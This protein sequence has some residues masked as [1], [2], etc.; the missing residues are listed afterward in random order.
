MTQSLT[1]GRPGRPEE[2][3]VPAGLALGQAV[4]QAQT[5][6]SGLLAAALADTG[7]PRETY[8]ALQRLALRGG[9][10]GR[11]EYISDLSDSLGMDL[12]AATEL[13]DGMVAG[14][15]LTSVDGTIRL[16]AAG[17]ELSAQLR[18]AIGDV[19]GPLWAAFD[20]ADLETTISTLREVT[21]AARQTLA[22]QRGSAAAGGRP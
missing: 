11:A 2:R 18:Q 4:G 8:L 16:A 6:L 12:W 15:L 19:T 17:A 9:A 7:T 14:R 22:A 21:A 13:T 3:D 20:P 10:A 5:V 1:D